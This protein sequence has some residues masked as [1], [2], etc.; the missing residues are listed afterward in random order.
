LC[1]KDAYDFGNVVNVDKN[2][3]CNIIVENCSLHDV[4][5]EREDILGIMKKKNWFL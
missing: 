1:T 2:N 4:T 3:N 5:L